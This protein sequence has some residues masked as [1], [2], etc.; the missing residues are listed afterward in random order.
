MRREDDVLR[1]GEPNP[2]K[3]LGPRPKAIGRFFGFVLSPFHCRLPSLPLLQKVATHIIESK[4]SS[5]KRKRDTMTPQSRISAKAT[6]VRS[7]ETALPAHHFH[8]SPPLRPNL[9]PCLLINLKQDGSPFPI[10]CEGPHPFKKASWDPQRKGHGVTWPKLRKIYAIEFPEDA[11]PTE[12]TRTC[13]SKLLKVE[14]EPFLTQLCNSQIA[15]SECL[16]L[17]SLLRNTVTSLDTKRPILIVAESD[18]QMRASS[19]S[20]TN[21]W[22]PSTSNKRSSTCAAP[23]QGSSRL[24]QRNELRQVGAVV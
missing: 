2:V 24:F 15:T 22:I 16:L 9:I 19:N 1:T 3:T 18:T 4:M 13:H 20:S 6:K 10:S 14:I 8:S 17:P 7:L 21:T 11:P 5:A 12:P 23:P